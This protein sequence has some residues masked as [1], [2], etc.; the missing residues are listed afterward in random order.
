MKRSRFCEE[1]IIGIRRVNLVL[2]AAI[3]YAVLSP[4]NASSVTV[5][6]NVSKKLR[7]FVICVSCLQ[8]CILS[9]RLDTF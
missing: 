9:S 5:A 1:Q 3:S 6:L 2:G 7:L 8:V 4:R